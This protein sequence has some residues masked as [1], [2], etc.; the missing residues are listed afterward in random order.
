[1]PVTERQKRLC[2]ETSFVFCPIEVQR[3]V[4]EV[5]SDEYHSRYCHRPKIQSVFCFAVLTK[6]EKEK[7][8]SREKKKKKRKKKLISVWNNPKRA[9]QKYY[10][11]LFIVDKYLQKISPFRFN[12]SFFKIK[13][14]IICVE[15]FN[16]C[17]LSI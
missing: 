15:N 3:F 8:P 16:D 9:A 12:D 7:I 13:I 11:V 2:L 5:G 14:I 17:L 1:M 4:K 6:I 10:K